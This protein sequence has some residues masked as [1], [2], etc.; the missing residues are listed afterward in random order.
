MKSYQFAEYGGTLTE[1]DNPTPTPEGDQVLVRV[2]GC[3]VC[4]S[5]IHI[6]EGFFDMGGGNKMELSRAHQLPFTLGHEIVG[7]VVA[8]GESAA[9]VAVGD[10]RVVYPWIGCGTCPVCQSGEEHLCARPSN[11]GVNAAGGY[12]DHVLVSHPRHLYAYGDIAPALACTYACSGL[13]AY[14]ALMKA[15]SRAEN[16]SLLIIGA[17]GVGMAGLAIAQTIFDN[18]EIIVADIDEAKLDAAKAAGAAHVINSSEADAAKQVLKL[19]GGGAAAA[20]DFVGAAASGQFGVGTIAKGGTLVIVGLFGGAL[21]VPMPLFPL[22]AMSIQG[23]YVGSPQEMDDLMTLVRAGKI[24]PIPVE[25]RAL[26]LADQTVRDL[27]DG[28]VVGRIVLEPAF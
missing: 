16:R 1:Y 5:D 14:S 6:W 4:H 24:Q 27:R 11:L 18:C 15:K 23:S 7:E 25:A 12:A 13:T 2:E 21:T 10:K 9:G 3:G 17:G 22:K 8:V 20:I 19:T 26:G 28:K